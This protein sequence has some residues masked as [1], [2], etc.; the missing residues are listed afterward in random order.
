MTIKKV[1]IITE[2][3]YNFGG[4][5]KSILELT[6]GLEE[7]NIEYDIYC[8]LYDKDKTFEDFKSMNVKFF[9]SRK[10]SAGIHS[11]WL[12]WKFSKLKLEGYD[13]Y[14]F[15]GF[16]SIA[17][18][19]YHHP[20]VI[21]EQGPLSYLYLDHDAG[22]KSGI[23]KIFKDIYLKLLKNI[24]QRNIKGVD[25]IFSLGQWSNKT[26]KESYPDK[27]NE[28]LFQPIDI[29]KYNISNKGKYY[30]SLT[31]LQKKVDIVIKAFQKMPDKE[32]HVYG[33]GSEEE[34]RKINELADG[35]SNIKIKGFA[36]EKD[37]PSIF[38]NCIAAI[39]INPNED[40]TM[41]L[42]EALA[43][44]K[45]GIS[46]NP[47][48]NTKD[49]IVKNTTGVLI[50]DYSSD[51]VANA[52]KEL[53]VDDAYVLKPFCIKRAKGFSRDNYVTTILKRLEKNQKVYIV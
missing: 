47:D 32:L 41:V 18:A 31:R 10:K 29:K 28:I 37:L 36:D 9:T 46:V 52:V 35:Y 12:R 27:P 50:K 1:A 13:G 23:K 51:D 38:G 20:N 44:G 5:E 7:K 39:S 15:F 49:Q 11:L 22:V 8:G 14:I 48:I 40:F 42:M 33:N 26:L 24:D 19:K 53:S 4:I 6:K 16:H 34:K 2:F 45:P 43:A 3:L 30:L 17:A 25:H 21:W